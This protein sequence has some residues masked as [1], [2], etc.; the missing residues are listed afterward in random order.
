MKSSRFRLN[1][2]VMAIYYE[3]FHRELRLR[4]LQNTANDLVELREAENPVNFI[5]KAESMSR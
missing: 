5:Q 3:D 1:L 4:K 2:T